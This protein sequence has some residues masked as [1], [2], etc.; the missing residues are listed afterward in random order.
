MSTAAP[1]PETLSVPL[2][3]TASSVEHLPDDPA[4]L[5]RM[6]LE[7]LDTLR[8]QRHDN[9]ELRDRLDRLL[10]RLYGPKGERFDPQQA[11][12]F[13]D[14]VP[15]P[16]TPAAPAAEPASEPGSAPAQRKGKPHGRGRL[17]DNLPREPVHHTLSEAERLCAACGTLRLD[18]GTDASEQVDYRPAVYV[19]KQ[20]V[21]HKYLCPCCARR[22]KAAGVAPA[23]SGA[24]EREPASTPLDATTAPAQAPP[25]DTNAAAPVPT[26]PLI[27]SAARPAELLPKCLAA[28]GL[29]AYL[30]VSKFLDHLPL[31]R[32][33]HISARHGW[34]LTRSTMCQWLADCGQGLRP[35][36]ELMVTRVLQSRVIHTDDTPVKIQDHAPGATA[37]GRLW[38]YLGD[39]Q[40]PYN[41]FDFTPNR[42]RDGPQRF[43]QNY[44]GY[45]QAD[46]FSGYDRLYLPDPVDGVTRIIE[47]A[48]NAHARRKFYDARSTDELHACQALAYYG[49]LYDLERQ[50]KDFDDATRRQ[51]RQDLA[52]PLLAKFQTWLQRQRDEV[53]PKSAL[54]EAVG[55][56]LNNW[57]ALLRY[58]EQ[59]FLAIDN[60]VA[61]R[62]MK[63]IA[64]GRKNWLFF[65]TENG[66][67]T[68]AVLLSFTTTCQRLGVE[69]WAYLQDVFTRLPATPADQLDT[70]LPDRW[71]AAR[72]EAHPSAPSPR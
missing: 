29:L 53:L 54:G 14:A 43:L 12:L 35:L 1:L 26:V 50:A 21:I 8:Q 62:E 72:S 55:Y 44:Q 65:G 6:I 24:T 67:A 15:A 11:T 71:A 13:G 64:I 19:V 57:T 40:H 52:V 23:A 47:V 20:H 3:A 38:D 31:Y 25:P 10:R 48:C 61:E 58:T 42:Q 70:L 9:A 41:V 30:I 32:L 28:P 66:G 36:Y 68:A 27:V 34:E 7:L 16:A 56:T 37:T 5:K 22:Q 4:T 45:L 46:A 39:R 17:P 51:L 59:G 49:Q 60:N 33:E 2:S 18:I 69:P 63:R